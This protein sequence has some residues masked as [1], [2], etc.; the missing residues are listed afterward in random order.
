MEKN[1]V[2][3]YRYLVLIEIET[4]YRIKSQRES[5]EYFR[6]KNQQYYH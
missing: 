6:F 3:K 5:I 4:T 2:L 1:P